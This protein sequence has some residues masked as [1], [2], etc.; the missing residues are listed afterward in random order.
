MMESAKF[1]GNSKK[2]SRQDV[3]PHIPSSLGYVLYFI[4]SRSTLKCIKQQMEVN[5][6]V[7]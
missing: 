1:M 7:T 2:Q 4:L 5:F 6:G 3:R